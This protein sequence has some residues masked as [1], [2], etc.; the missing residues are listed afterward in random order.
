MDVSAF[1]LMYSTAKTYIQHSS[2]IMDEIVEKK[3]ALSKL[4]NKTKQTDLLNWVKQEFWVSRM[5]FID[6]T[7][8]Q[9]FDKVC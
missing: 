1:L 4:K 6:K 8:P 5:I 3:Q 9:Y 7:W 2:N